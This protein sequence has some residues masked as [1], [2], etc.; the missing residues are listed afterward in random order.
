MDKTQKIFWA[1]CAGTFVLAVGGLLAFAY[2]MSM[3]TVENR[4]TIA[5]NT[6]DISEVFD[7]PP[8]QS[9][10]DNIFT[11]KVYVQNTGTAPCYVRV[12]ADF[13]NS[14]V[15][16]RSFISDSSDDSPPIFYS[17]ER[18]LDS[19][20]ERET[21]AEHLNSGDGWVFVPDDSGTVLAG[22]YY[23]PYPL[24]VQETTPLLFSY[25]KTVNPTEDDIDQYDIYVYS[26][27]IQLTDL[28]GQTY[29]DYAAAWTDFLSR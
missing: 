16:S 24:A 2:F 17:A 9:T 8:E 20:D 3:D 4:I 10:E 27:S 28:N 22:F 26:E 11:K 29:A 6:I 21:F 5:D 14:F 12:Y 7:P 19:T 13:S 23:Y 15:R 1:V 18:V 25:I